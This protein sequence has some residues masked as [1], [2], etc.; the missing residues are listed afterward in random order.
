MEYEDILGDL[1][2]CGLSCRKCFAKSQG[3]IALL[4]AQL[5]ERLGSFDVYAER[6]SAFLTAF[7]DYPP[8]K[9]LLA[10]LA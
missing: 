2:P 3:D 8:F 7:E 9:E 4:S 1:A 6:F 10:Y 5:R